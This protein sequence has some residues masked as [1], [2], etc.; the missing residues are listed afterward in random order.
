ML[1]PYDDAP[2]LPDG[3]RV[4]VRTLACGEWV[5]LEVGPG[6]GWFL[7]ER[8]QVEQRAALIGLEIRRKWASVV[9]GRL[10]QRGLGSRA[11]VFAED[12]GIALARL[13]PAES[14]KRVFVHFPDPWWKKRHQKRLLLSDRFIDQVARLLEPGGQFFVQTDVE[15]RA[16][17]HA[18]RV[19]A[20]KRFVSDGDVPDSP[21]V[22]DNPYGAR[23]PRER[24]AIADGLPVHRLRWARSLL[25]LILAATLGWSK[26]AQAEARIVKGPYLTGLSDS[27]VDVRFELDRGSPASLTVVRESDAGSRGLVFSVRDSGGMQFARAA[28]LEAATRYAYSVRVGGAVSGEGHFTTAPGRD[29]SAPINFLVYGD[30][31][32][33]PTAHAVVVRA[34]AQL[35]CDFLVNT[36]DVV[37]DGSSAEDWQSFF[38]VEGALLRDHP[39]FVA[40]GNHELYGD[41]A[42]AGFARYL[43]FMDAAGVP[44]LYGTVRLGF[45]RFFF[46]NATHDWKSGEERDWLVRE[47]TRADAEDGLVWRIAVT[48]DGPWSSGPHGGSE[49]LNAAHVPELLAAHRIDLVLSGHDHIYV[50]GSAGELKYIV[51][52]GGGAPLYPIRPDDPTARKAEATYHFVE[53]N[54]TADAL[55]ISARRPDGT[56]FDRCGFGKSRPWDCDPPPASPS[57][58]GPREGPGERPEA[59]RPSSRCGCRLPGAGGNSGAFPGA[60]FGLAALF[61]RRLFRRC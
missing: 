3:D 45:V 32:S 12:A 31:R 21:Y 51:S 5:E 36:G 37:E 39:I 55:R 22:S 26:V 38:D 47:L 2:R 20:D 8:A 11:R 7:V 34:M 4:D 1:R 61:V 28:G 14:V 35:P 48:H 43:G 29:S 42:G 18:Q 27:S 53:I 30:D 60:A 19:G 40:I 10:R 52:G 50:R 13:G 9:D 57:G 58:S 59:S 44:H 16:Q 6:R 56:V 54:A 49:R 17:A 25:A 15:E 46:L 41:L 24:R 33:D 23:S